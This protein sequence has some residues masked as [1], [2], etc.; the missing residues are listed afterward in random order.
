MEIGWLHV[1]MGLFGGLALFL[2]GLERL[3]EGLQQVAGSALRTVLARLQ[4]SIV[5]ELERVYDL[6]SRIA[7]GVLASAGASASAS[8]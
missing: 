2:G 3:S 5:D 6:S 7:A 8:R 1:A 4:M